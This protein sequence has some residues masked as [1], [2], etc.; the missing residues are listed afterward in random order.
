MKF[1]QL[2][3]TV[4]TSRYY[5]QMIE[6]EKLKAQYNPE[7]FHIWIGLHDGPKGKEFDMKHSPHYRFLNGN[8]E[9]YWELQKKFGRKPKWIENKI[10]KF[11]GVLESVKK[12]GFIENV[13]ALETPLVSNKYNKGLEI[14]EGHHR[15]AIALFLKMDFI[16]CEIIRRKA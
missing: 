5:F 7:R 6:I 3:K 4:D 11:L 1:R 10:S 9:P 15:V 2:V 8:K 13:S 16:P 12:N 14:W